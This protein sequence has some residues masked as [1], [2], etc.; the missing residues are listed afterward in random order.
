LT[1]FVSFLGTQTL[2]RRIDKSETYGTGS[3]AV[4]FAV[5]GRVLGLGV[6][7]GIVIEILL[8]TRKHELSTTPEPEVIT[9]TIA[10]T[11]ET[12]LQEQLD[13]VSPLLS[14]KLSFQDSVGLS[15]E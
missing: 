7:T 6:T 1:D 8:I 13:C 9:E 2:I 15:M 12:E 14:D 11:D 10:F 5:V 3:S 4:L